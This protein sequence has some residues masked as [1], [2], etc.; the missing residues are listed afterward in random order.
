MRLVGSWHFVGFDRA[1]PSLRRRVS[2]PRLTSTFERSSACH[3]SRIR[4][5]IKYLNLVNLDCSGG[6]LLPRLASRERAWVRASLHEFLCSRIVLGHHALGFVHRQ[7]DFSDHGALGEAFVRLVRPGREDSIPT[8][9]ASWFRR[10]SGAGCVA[11]ALKINRLDLLRCNAQRHRTDN[12]AAT[13]RQIEQ[14]L[15]RATC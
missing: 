15:V 13:S 10:T 9:Q 7:T 14:T 12:Q 4:A 1:N 6:P 8:M 5:S 2:L 3:A 11:H